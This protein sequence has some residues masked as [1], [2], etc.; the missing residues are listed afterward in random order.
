LIRQEVVLGWI[1]QPG[2]RRWLTHEEI[3]RGVL[4]A[5]DDPQ[6]RPRIIGELA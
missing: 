4:A 1:N 6:R 3:S 5:L 2:A